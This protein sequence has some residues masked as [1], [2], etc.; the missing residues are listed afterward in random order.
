M[1]N[2]NV[3][4]NPSRKECE[5]IIRRILMTEVLEKGTNEHFKNATDF[6]GYFQSL[7]PAGDSLTKQVQRAVKAMNMPK[8]DGGYYIINKTEEQLD[9]DKEL[10]F[11]LKKTQA[12]PVS[13][14]SC[15]TLFLQVDP[16]CKDY[17]LQLIEESITFSDK[18]VTIVNTS[19]GLLF[20]TEKKQQLKI[21]LESLTNR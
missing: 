2:Q 18:Y 7:Y 13:L 5:D 3:R 12:S 17:L 15:E 6:L 19:R 8:D 10:S 9:Q 1:E 4:R 20:Y 14:S 21:L 11:L 16:S